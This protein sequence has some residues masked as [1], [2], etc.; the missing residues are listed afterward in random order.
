[1]ELFEAVDELL[2]VC[3][4]QNPLTWRYMEEMPVL[5]A[6]RALFV[7]SRMLYWESRL[8]KVLAVVVAAVE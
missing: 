4:A 8:A 5:V 3:L 2:P 7:F 1:M 6:S